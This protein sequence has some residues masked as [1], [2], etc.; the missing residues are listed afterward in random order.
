[1][2][3][4]IPDYLSE[5]SSIYRG[6]SLEVLK[7]FSDCSVDAIVTD[8]PAG[9]NFM[10]RSWDKD[11]GGRDQWVAWLAEIMTEALRVLKPGAYA[12]VW[13]LPRTSHWTGW[14]LET[15][16]FEIR[17]RVAHLFGSGMP[18]SLTAATGM[19]E[20]QGTAL[21]PS[22]EDWWLCRKPIEGTVVKNIAK[23]GTG[24][25]NI[26]LCRIPR[27][28]GDRTE[29]GV[30]GDE[31]CGSANVYGF[32]PEDRGPYTPHEQGRWPKNVVLGEE[33]AADL[34]T[35][36]SGVAR[37]FY[38]AKPTKKERNLGC[39]HLPVKSGGEATGRKDGS[40]GVNNP[41]AG[42]GRTG[43]VR[44]QHP[45]LKGIQLMR[46][47]VRLITPPGGI[48]LDPFA[49]SGTTGIA[50]IAEGCKFVGIEKEEEYLP[51]LLG[52]IKYA[53]ETR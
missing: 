31:G 24:G 26:D 21:T 18:K 42:A 29:Y 48:V 36:S 49:G 6:D 40:A 1:M 33:V 23:Y 46:Y 44:N 50:A 52:R 47:L 45:T 10:Q 5:H 12:L 16:G 27:G 51:I 28:A 8:P 20:G 37:Y 22:A 3:P 43:G 35:T 39:D 14:A 32:R 15:A 19:P 41:R 11:K 30:D 34:N 53:E 7:G 38:C 17:D 25:L 9:V 13:A 4:T 2:I